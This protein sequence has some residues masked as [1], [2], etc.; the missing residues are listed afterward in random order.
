MS[1]EASDAA[2]HGRAHQ[3]FVDVQGHQ[4]SRAAL[5]HLPTHGSVGFHVSVFTSGSDLSFP[6]LPD[7]LPRNGCLTNHRLSSAHDPVYGGGFLVGAVVAADR[8]DLRVR[9]VLLEPAQGLLGPLRKT[10]LPALG[11]HK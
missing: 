5:Q 2:S 7:H 6:Y 1:V 3:V 8:Q 9:V 10:A 4:V 11:T